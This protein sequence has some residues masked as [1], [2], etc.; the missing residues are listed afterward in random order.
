MQEIVINDEL[1][2]CVPDGFHVMT[3]EERSGMQMLNG[4]EWIGLSDQAYQSLG[5]LEEDQWFF[6]SAAVRER[7]REKLGKI[8]QRTDECLWIQAGRIPGNGHRRGE[9]SRI[10]IQI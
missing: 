3:E 5:G 10:P 9:S 6:C 7:P 2:L 8:G 1:V 4:G